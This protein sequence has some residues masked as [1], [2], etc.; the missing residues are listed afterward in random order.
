MIPGI[1]T[2]GIDPGSLHTGYGF[3]KRVGSKL[4]HVL[5]GTIHTDAKQP[6][7]QRL[8]TIRDRLEELLTTCPPDQAAVEDVFF[9]KNANSALKLGQVRGVILVTLAA[10]QI[11]VA[12]FPPALV[13]RSIV[14]SGKAEKAQMQ[15]VVQAVLGLK[16]LPQVDES[17]A[18][19]IAV[20][21]S[22]AARIQRR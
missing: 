11:P 5:S 9:S 18:L 8:L 1:I 10:R 20:C 12:S 7:E 19:A 22:N 17:D 16:E 3:I 21:A 13:K 4:V 6:M 14:G 2:L 15:R